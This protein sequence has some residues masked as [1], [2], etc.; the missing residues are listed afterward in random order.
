MAAINKFFGLTTA[1]GDSKAAA[2]AP[3]QGPIVDGDPVTMQLWVRGTVLQIE[4][5]KDLL[6]KLEGSEAEEGAGATIRTIPLSGPAAKSALETIE[7]FWTLKNKIR[8]VTPSN[9]TPSADIKLRVITPLERQP[10]NATPDDAEGPPE[11]AS[12]VPSSVQRPRR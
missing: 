8:M 2:K 9:L 5:V 3:A 7:Q 12:P 1:A 10:E 11:D 6:E 4:Q